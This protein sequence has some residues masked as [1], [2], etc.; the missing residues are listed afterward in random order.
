VKAPGDRTFEVVRNY[1][2]DIVTIDDEAIA[3][4]ILM[5]LE[6]VKLVVE[7]AGAIGPAALLHGKIPVQGPVACLISGGNIDVNFIAR[8]I[9]R[10]LV[11]AGRRVIIT[12]RVIDR[13]ARCR[14]CWRL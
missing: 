12:T 13:R 4:A 6:R 8:I 5:L 3:S 11:K 7:G 9:E 14:S 1:V 2:D 10:G